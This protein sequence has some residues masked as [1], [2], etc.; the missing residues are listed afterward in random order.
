MN[1]IR[2]WVRSFFGFSRTETNAFLILLP[3]MFL[4]VF[5][6]PAYKTYFTHRQKDY[7][8]EQKQ[9]DSLITHWQKKEQEKKDSS[10]VTPVSLFAFNPNTASK[11]ELARLGFSSYVASRLENYRNKG[12]KF[13]IK[14]DL[15]RL[16]GM[17]TALY[18]NI[19]AWIDLPVERPVK[20]L[21]EKKEIEL[22]QKRSKEKFDLNLAD[23]SQFIS[24]Y[25]IG[26]KLSVRIIKYR[27]RLGGFITT[28]QL[29]EVYGLDSVVISEIKKKTFITENFQPKTL[30]LNSASEKELAAHPYIKYS[31]AK[32]ITA[33]RFQHGPFKSIDDLMKIAIL[34]KGAFEKI[35]PYLS[36][37]P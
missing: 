10:F 37:N 29:S 5:M 7:T 32:A 23:S 15:L 4:I 27:D 25:G 19:Y 31:I 30:E 12:G 28:N 35:K 26:S 24:V 36:L 14:S 17:D 33:Y 11:K 3:L 1:R 8:H 21:E 13:I 6:V 18:S 9:L 34:D 2:S 20:K 16:Y 22:A